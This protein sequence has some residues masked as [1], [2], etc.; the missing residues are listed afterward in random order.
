MARIADPRWS[1]TVRPDVCV[2]HM[3]RNSLRYAS[4][5][6]WSQIM[7][8]MRAVYTAPTVEAAQAHCSVLAARPSGSATK[9]PH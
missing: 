5:K 4:K 6:H 3:V 9:T 2:V 8:Q 1:R 7:R